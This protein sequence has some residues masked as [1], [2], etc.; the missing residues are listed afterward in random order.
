MARGD[1]G[2][3]VIEVDPS[4]KHDL[5]AELAKSGTTLKDWFISAATHFCKDAVQPDLFGNSTLNNS[6]E[7]QHSG[8]GR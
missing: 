5:Y 6:P 3:I 8:T 7:D 4:L 2:R 1:S